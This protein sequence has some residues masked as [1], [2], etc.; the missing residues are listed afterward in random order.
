MQAIT[1][2]DPC[3]R[4]PRVCTTSQTELA[5]LYLYPTAL[6]NLVT[7]VVWRDTHG[8]NLSPAQRL[9]HFPT[10]PL[11]SLSWFHDCDLGLVTSSAQGT[12]WQ[13]FEGRIQLSGSQSRPFTSWTTHPG[14]SGMV[15]FTADQAHKLFN[16]D[17]TIIND[18]FV[19]AHTLLDKR[20]WPL[21]DDLTKAAEGDAILAALRQHLINQPSNSDRHNLPSIRELG[22]HWVQRLN[23]QAQAW[24]R[25][26]STRQVQR[27][28]KDYTGRSLR[29][30]E[31][32]VKTEQVFFAAQAQYNQG[33]TVDWATM[34]QDSGF[35]DQAHLNRWT[36]RISGFAPGDFAQRFVADE[37]FWLYRLW[38]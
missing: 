24:Q 8:L 16:I 28:I 22:R 5:S 21:L 17:L 37:S 6:Q 2:P 9:S 3:A 12:A 13:P 34:A 10:T 29:E 15:C 19:P 4:A 31:M 20:W 32:M 14:R 7:A 27:L 36:K 11:V 35:A 33:L 25:L 26:Y 30:W 38:I 23:I 1:C 18:R